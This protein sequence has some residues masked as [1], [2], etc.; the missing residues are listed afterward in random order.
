[1]IPHRLPIPPLLPYTTLF[2]SPT[3]IPGVPRARRNAGSPPRGPLRGYDAEHLGARE[4]R[5]AF[6]QGHVVV[7][8]GH[9][10]DASRPAADRDLAV[11]AGQVAA[12][13]REPLAAARIAEP[14]HA[15]DQRRLEGGGVPPPGPKPLALRR[16]ES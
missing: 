6:L 3:P 10:R 2:R 4:R 16:L 13:P 14:A 12:D 15:L 1:L 7:P 8:L 9:D 11:P 5:Q